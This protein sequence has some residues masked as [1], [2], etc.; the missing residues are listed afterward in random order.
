MGI[1]AVDPNIDRIYDLDDATK[2]RRMA[3]VCGNWQGDPNYDA[4]DTGMFPVQALCC[5][6]NRISN[7]GREL[8]AF[9]WHAAAGRE[10]NLRA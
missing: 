6:T 8:L 2:V 3:I 4:L 10:R 5:L 7:Q 1:L 9:R